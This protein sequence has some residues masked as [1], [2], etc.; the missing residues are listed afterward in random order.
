MKKAFL[1]LS[2]VLLVTVTYQLK[3]QWGPINDYPGGITDACG[4]FSLNGDVYIAGGLGLKSLYKY[5]TSS[6]TWARMADIGGT[7]THAW[8]SVFAANGKGY[9]MGG[10]YATASEVSDELWEY[11]PATDS[12]TAKTKFPG[13]GRDGMYVFVIDNVA[14]M[15]GGFNGSTVQSDLWKYEPVTDKWTKL[16]GSPIGATIFSSGFTISNN[17]YM[18][19]GAGGSGNTELNILY[20][21]DPATD[22]WTKKADYPGTA[23]QAGFAYSYNGEGYY[24]GGMANYD[25]DFQ[26]V[27]KY[28][29]VSDSW[30]KI[31][32]TPHTHAA[33][34][35]AAVANGIAYVGTGGSVGTGSLTFSDKMY[36]YTIPTSITEISQ[37]EYVNIYPNPATDNI[38]IAGI[39]EIESITIYDITG[40]L[41]YT[42]NEVT[43][44][45]VST[46]SLI[47]GIYYIEVK[48]G[49]NII[50]QKFI[51]Q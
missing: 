37:N 17:G 33:W 21:Y 1:L 13:G 42:E 9:V 35:T 34:S 44:N 3:A 11:D 24:G 46:E 36:K 2:T 32:N 27:W 20:Q 5:E 41:L 31:A 14:Y 10:A 18:I 19:G 38:T 12:W 39:K 45:E 43:N 25:T 48:N 51:K 15:G 28:N 26:D 49:N 6:G 16:T 7:L 47:P 40:Q 29:P 23:R 22:T 50:T 8:A 4:S 30:A